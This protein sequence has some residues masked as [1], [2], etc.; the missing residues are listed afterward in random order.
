MRYAALRRI[1]KDLRLLDDFGIL[2]LQGA[3][4]FTPLQCCVSKAKQ[5]SSEQ[6]ILNTWP[7]KAP[8]Q[9][10]HPELLDELTG[11]Q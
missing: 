10:R 1:K 8:V 11:K 7:V 4:N 3:F 2:M 6:G 9:S 5:D